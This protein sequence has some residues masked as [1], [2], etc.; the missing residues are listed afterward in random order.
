MQKNTITKPEENKTI[1]LCSWQNKNKCHGNNKNRQLCGMNKNKNAANINKN[2]KN[3]NAGQ[4]KCQA[5][6]KQCCGI[7]NYDA[8]ATASIKPCRSNKNNKNM[9]R[10]NWKQST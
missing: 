4:Q 5:R 7:N 1:H 6:R 8:D 10:D 3:T 9:P 2:N